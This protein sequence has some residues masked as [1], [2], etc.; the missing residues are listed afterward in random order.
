MD[1]VGNVAEFVDPALVPAPGVRIAAFDGEN[2]DPASG[3]LMGAG[4]RAFTPWG[5]IA[6][7]SAGRAGYETIRANDEQGRRPRRREHPQPC[8]AASRR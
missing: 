4:I 8:S 5:E 6:Y 7:R 3:R 1:G 2:A